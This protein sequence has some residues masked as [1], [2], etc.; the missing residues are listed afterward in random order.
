MARFV[1]ALSLFVVALAGSQQ[2]SPVQKVIELLEDNKMKV[3]NDLKAEEKEMAAFASYCDDENKD[4]N[5]AIQTADRSIEGLK[6]A[7]ED[8]SAKIE[9]LNDDISTLG[10]EMASKDR[11]L[12]AAHDLRHK[13]KSDF[14]STEKELVE[15]VD[16]L[17][18]AVVLIKR[19]NAFVQ[20]GSA[21][22]T[23]VDAKA[24]MKAAMKVFGEIVDAGRVESG[25]R[26]KLQDMMQTSVDSDSYEKLG[27]PQASVSNY[28]SSSGG[29]LG[30]LTAMKEK[31]EETLSGARMAEMRQ[32][33]NFDTFA[34]GLTD[35]LS[36]AKEKMS[37]AKKGLAET[38]EANGKAN[39]GLVETQNNKAADVKFVEQL[40]QNCRETQESW[41]ERQ[42]SAREE[43]NAINKAVEIL[44]EGVRVFMQVGNKAKGPSDL[45][46][47]DKDFDASEGSSPQ[48]MARAKVVQKL[49][50]LSSKFSSYALMELAGTA[51]SDPFVKIKGLVEEM[52]AKLVNEANEE[53]TQKG[54]C[55]EETA[56]STS[57]KQEKSMTI[58]KL[59]SR[60]DKAASARAQLEQSIKDLESE[61]AAIDRGNAEAT[62]I[63]AEEHATYIKASKDYRDAADAVERASKVLK[64]YYESALI[65][66]SAVRSSEKQ[67]EF[68]AAKSDASHAILSILEMSAEDFTK[69][70]MKTETAESEAQSSF[71][72]LSQ[73]NKVSKAAKQTEVKAAGSEIKSLNVALKNTKEDYDLT[74]KELD[75]VMEY[76]EKLK[77]QCESKAMSYG[78]K[79]ARREAEIDGLKE[80]L[81]L[82]SD[83]GAFVQTNVQ[84]RGARLH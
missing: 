75:S 18:R 32:Q 82:L 53:A 59:Q 83:G 38:T 39:G 40:T 24:A 19:G 77:P 74:S 71:E 16:Q 45:D 13:E 61:V 3:L 54:F 4:K 14:E 49:K 6:A 52:I 12:A 8:G 22:K 2:G 73:D 29:I 67:P 36:I 21:K 9:G 68:G 5:Y 84:L 56:K 43:L 55:D 64:A 15:A 17:E 10:S 26:R 69:M 65:Q 33:H 66:V 20:T 76:L 48:D 57:S 47:D 30:E 35:A 11:D 46:A 23:P 62:K 1:V 72:T 7:I 51:A 79:K 44:G 41:T 27:Q 81:S 80:A 63:R 28:E 70:L 78:E 58:D 34:Q 42:D 25:L 37:D 50:T 60:T 31:A